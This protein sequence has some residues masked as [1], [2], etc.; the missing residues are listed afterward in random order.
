MGCV[1]SQNEVPK[2]NSN[3]TSAYPGG[4]G[5]MNSGPQFNSSGAGG[6][7][8]SM[9]PPPPPVQPPQ[10]ALMFLGLYQYDARTSEDLS[11]KKGEK[12]QIINNA[13]GDWWLARSMATGQEGYIPSNYVAPMESVQAQ[14]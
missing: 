9:P 1:S 11:F 12:L 14:E 13:D 3:T 8:I 6:M 2:A 4:Q 10:G 5:M 7:G